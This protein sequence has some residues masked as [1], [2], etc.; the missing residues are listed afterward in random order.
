MGE[1][2]VASAALLAAFAV[3]LAVWRIR[4]PRRHTRAIAAI[5]LGVQGA[6]LASLPR[7]AAAFPAL[8]IPS[9]VPAATWVS[10][11]GFALSATMAYAITYTAIEADSPSLVLA[12]AIG[13]A[14]A[15]G[16]SREEI[17]RDMTD[18][19]LVDPRIRDLVRDG[20]VRIDGDRYRIT[21]KGRCMARLFA[22]HRRLLGLGTGG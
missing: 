21:P 7:L 8:G 11:S 16:L 9:P 1:P 6:V 10:L 17:L 2:A 5:F 3:H 13:R 22:R 4:L 15:G 18:A 12:L 20:L 19:T 14:G